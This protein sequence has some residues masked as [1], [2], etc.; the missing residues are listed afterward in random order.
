M[1]DGPLRRFAR[2]VREAFSA[3]WALATDASARA[4]VRGAARRDKPSV[5]PRYVHALLLFALAGAAIAWALGAAVLLAMRP[6]FLGSWN[7]AWGI[8][9]VALLTATVLPTPYEPTLIPLAREGVLGAAVGVT[10]A[11]A[12]IALGAAFVYFLGGALRQEME[13]WTQHGI[14][15]GFLEYSERFARRAGYP[16]FLILFSIPFFPDTF[17]VYLFSL[18]GMRLK[19]FLVVCFVGGVVRSL[20]ALGA[21]RLF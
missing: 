6:D 11:A 9:A 10:A 8:F 12:G 2:A 4:E 3:A 18:L 20:V 15:R 19:P 7:V 14:V 21:I 13:R 16:A 1:P 5:P 17:L